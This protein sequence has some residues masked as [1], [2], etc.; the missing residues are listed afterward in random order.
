MQ[1]LAK[2]YAMKDLGPLSSFLGISV[3]RNSN[4]LFLDQQAYARSIIE[5]ADLVH[6]NPVSTPVDTLGKQRSSV[7]K[8]YS[9]PTHYRGLA[10]DL[11]Y[12]TFTSPDISYAVQKVCLHMHLPHEEHMHDLKRI[13]RYITGTLSL[14]IHISKCTTISI[15]SY[16]YID[17]AG[18]PTPIILLLGT[19][20]IWV[21]TSSFGPLNI[22]QSSLGPV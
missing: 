7:G 21:I 13:I 20:F 10:R 17:W 12:L 14:G 22:R 9:K 6:C 15:I 2:E 3:S 8:L 1:L 5:R 19:V 16:T 11:Q 4:G 18:C